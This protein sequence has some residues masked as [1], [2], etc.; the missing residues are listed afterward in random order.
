M[1]YRA[2]V[3]LTYWVEGM[4]RRVEAGEVARDIPRESQTWL[5]AQGCIT[6]VNDETPQEAET[7]G[8]VRQ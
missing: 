2:N 4:P 6:E 1:T 3:G 8:E 7:D 5:L